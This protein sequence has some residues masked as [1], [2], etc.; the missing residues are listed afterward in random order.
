M[1]H[2]LAVSASMGLLATAAPAESEFFE[3]P[4]DFAPIGNYT[5]M[6]SGE[7]GYYAKTFP[8]LAAQVYNVADNRYRIIFTPELMARGE[9]YHT[10]DASLEGRVLSFDG[11]G[12]SGTVE[13]GILKGKTNMDPKGLTFELKKQPW[14][15]TNMGTAP[16]P[17]AVVLF[18]G[19]NTNAWEHSDGRACTWRI[20]DGVM[21]I[22]PG[23][24]NNGQNRK[25]GLG[26]NLRTKEKFRDLRLHIEFRYPVEPGRGGQGRGNSGVFLQSNLYEVQ[27]L[28]SYGL[29]GTWRECGS[30]YK[31]AAP[32]VNAAAPPL[33]WNAYDI[34]YYGAR[35]DESGKLAHP[36]VITVMHNG[37]IIHRLQDIEFPTVHNFKDRQ[38]PHTK[39]A[40]P[41]ELQDHG[42]YIQFRNIWAVDLEKHPGLGA[43]RP[44]HLPP[45]H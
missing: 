20:V 38:K 44:T 32:H 4:S 21:E 22:V 23:G 13:N 18:D 17:E 24:G 26:G 31:L 12:W 41:I 36:P 19:K 28:N 33:E 40:G 8:I 6:F 16:P 30:L 29:T 1:K 14:E 39:E 11:D 15:P 34:E 7:K 42:N 5:G 2:V 9:V 10:A 43:N 45:T 3:N 27:V 25:K 35:F 37:E